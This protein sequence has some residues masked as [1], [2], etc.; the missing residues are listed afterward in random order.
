MSFTS[1]RTQT[2]FERKQEFLGDLEMSDL[3]KESIRD[4]KILKELTEDRIRSMIENSLNE[5]NSTTGNV[6]GI[7]KPVLSKMVRK[8]IGKWLP[9]LDDDEDLFEDEENWRQ[10]LDDDDLETMEWIEKVNNT[11]SGEDDI[12]TGDIIED[13]LEYED[14][15]LEDLIAELES[16]ANANDDEELDFNFDEEEEILRKEKCDN[17]GGRVNLNGDYEYEEVDNPT[18]RKRNEKGYF[19]DKVGEMLKP[20]SQANGT[21]GLRS[22][23]RKRIL[24]GQDEEDFDREKEMERF[25]KHNLE[26]I[27]RKPF[28]NMRSVV[29][30]LGASIRLEQEEKSKNLLTEIEDKSEVIIS[31]SKKI[32]PSAAEKKR[33]LEFAGI[34]QLDKPILTDTRDPKMSSATKRL[35][36]LDKG[37]TSVS[38][39]LQEWENEEKQDNL[40]AE[41]IFKS[42]DTKRIIKG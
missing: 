12:E 19:Y 1:T 14:E 18:Q 7:S 15:E 28:E 25:R 24:A 23:K 37:K 16:V 27:N 20:V 5:E 30:P 21:D 39:L 29:S 10:E 22:A 34:K 9:V 2:K 4:A 26:W 40:V 31:S 42:K 35:A 33:M 11:W 36:G 8:E 41:A 17:D 6:A 38:K 3:I 13:W 32:I